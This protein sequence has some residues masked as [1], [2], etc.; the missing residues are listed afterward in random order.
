MQRSTIAAYS[1]TSSAMAS[2]DGGTSRP[3]GQIDF[4]QCVT[5]F[6]G[7]F[8]SGQGIRCN[9]APAIGSFLATFRSMHPWVQAP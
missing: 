8:V 9:G 6:A 2:S 1:I 5:A 4:D 7:A 3:G